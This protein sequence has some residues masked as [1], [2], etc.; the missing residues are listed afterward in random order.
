ME[1]MKKIENL[2]RNNFCTK[3]LA[4]CQIRLDKDSANVFIIP[5]DTTIKV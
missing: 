1:K 2:K 5:T 3:M 4:D